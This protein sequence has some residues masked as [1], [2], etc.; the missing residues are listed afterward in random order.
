MG[1]ISSPFMIDSFL[2]KG[3]DFV[4]SA[5]YIMW[6]PMLAYNYYYQKGLL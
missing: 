4:M 1:G 5:T 6:D 3:A 2:K